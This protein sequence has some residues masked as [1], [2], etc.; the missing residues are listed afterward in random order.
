MTPSPVHSVAFSRLKSLFRVRVVLF[1]LVVLV[2]TLL[3]TPSA[4]FAPTHPTSKQQYAS[5]RLINAP[6]RPTRLGTTCSMAAKD[7]DD[8][9]S[10][11]QRIESTKCVVVGALSGGFSVVLFTALHDIAFGGQ[12]FNN[13]VAQWE[14]DTDMGSLESALFA[15]VY[16]YC[17][18][19]DDNPMLNQGVI[20]A[21]VLVRTLSRIRVPSYCTAAPLDCK[22]VISLLLTTTSVLHCGVVL[23][24]IRWRTFSFLH[25]L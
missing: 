3:A 21:F 24:L 6:S 13:G 20:G 16:R 25:T 19:K 11:G 9:F 7:D 18:R 14:F 12:E 23:L 22:L 8:K 2:S 17:I 4:A 1:A 10:F 15:I 5:S